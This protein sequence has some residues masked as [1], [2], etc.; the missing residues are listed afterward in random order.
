MLALILLL[1]P[2]C[3]AQSVTVRVIN[4]KNGRALRK[5]AVSVQFF[6]EKPPGV[7]PPLNI[8]TDSNG[9][10]QFNLPDPIPPHLNVRVTL[11]S[12]HWHCACGLMANTETVVHKGVVEIAPEKTKTSTALA[13][14]EPGHIDLF[15]IR[16]DI[17]TKTM[18]RGLCAIANPSDRRTVRSNFAGGPNVW[19]AWNHFQAP[20]TSN[21]CVS[22]S[23]KK[24]ITIDMILI[25][26]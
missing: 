14:P 13:N 2:V 25:Q 19:A 1:C 21:R 9:E 22:S 10:A 17:C 6:Y 3:F 5:Q 11:T 4:G 7:S 20:M 16:G 8:E 23:C 18:M 26:A 12:E 15:V 24:S